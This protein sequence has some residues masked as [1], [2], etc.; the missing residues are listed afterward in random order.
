MH[1]SKNQWFEFNKQLNN[2]LLSYKEA[3]FYFTI[4]I[5]G[6]EKCGVGFIVIFLSAVW[7]LILT[8]PIHCRGSI[9]KQ[10]M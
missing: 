5:D 6:L 2:E 3:V 4:L 8:A 1:F 9:G 7:T 10:V